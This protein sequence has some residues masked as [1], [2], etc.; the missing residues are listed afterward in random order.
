MELSLVELVQP[1]SVPFVER[2]ASPFTD[3]GEGIGYMREREKSEEEEGLRGHDALHLLYVGPAGPIDDDGDS[4]TS[5]P[6][7]S[8]ALYVGV[9]NRSWHSIPSRQVA[10]LADTPSEL[11]RELGSIAPA[12]PTLLVT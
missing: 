6:C 12:R 9:V 5:R 8:L 3:E 1:F 2:P 11:V 10:W 4:S 7:L